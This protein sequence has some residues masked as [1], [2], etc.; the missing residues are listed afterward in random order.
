[1]KG[2][3][4]MK[5]NALVVLKILCIFVFILVLLFSFSGC[6]SEADKELERYKKAKVLELKDYANTMKNYSSYTQ[7]GLQ[8]VEKQVRE[9]INAIKKSSDLESAYEELKTAKLRVASAEIKLDYNAQDLL[10]V[11]FKD[12]FREESKI[13]MPNYYGPPID[14]NSD[15]NDTLP[16][17][18]IYVV[19]DQEQL[20]NIFVEPPQ[21]NF[22]NEM[23]LIVIYRS[24]YENYT[25]I[26]KIALE[27]KVLKVYVINERKLEPRKEGNT[28]IP[29][30]PRQV[31]CVYKLDKLE[32]LETELLFIST[33][34]WS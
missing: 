34:A 33:M 5:T 16:R 22:E 13:Y 17:H 30:Q 20:D 24:S 25:S 2:R 4:K 9:G 27:E 26:N 12:T 3:C 29:P 1:M 8:T 18:R 15:E 28:G 23:I 7:K 19:K 6:K 14:N 32:V 21:V 31:V 11:Y 10:Q